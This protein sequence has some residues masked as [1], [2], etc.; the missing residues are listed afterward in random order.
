MFSR[1]TA[2][3][4]F[5][6]QTLNGAAI[7]MQFGEFIKSR[8]TFRR[9]SLSKLS[10]ITGYNACTLSEFESNRNIP[11]T[12]NDILKGELKNNNIGL[13]NDYLKFCRLADALGFDSI[14]LEQIVKINN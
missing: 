11:V 3:N 8:R 10:T 13:F 2:I 12:Y 6:L 5:K 9:L 7:T 4:Y 1:V 14:E